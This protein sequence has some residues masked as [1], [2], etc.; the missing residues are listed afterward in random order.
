M[1]KQKGNRQLDNMLNVDVRRSAP[2]YLQLRQNIL[3]LIEKQVLKDGDKLPSETEIAIQ[4]N[5]SRGTVRTA[6]AELAREGIISRTP[7]R[8]SFLTLKRPTYSIKIGVFSPLFPTK[9]DSF[10]DFFQAELIGGIREAALHAG[11]TL[12]FLP[13][14]KKEDDLGYEIPFREDMDAILILAPRKSDIPILYEIEK[15][16]MPCISISAATGSN[17][18]YVASDNLKGAASVMEYLFSL[19][20]QRIALITNNLDCFDSQA[21]YDGYC[22]A[23][24]EHNLPFNKKI[25]KIIGGFE[26]GKWKDKAKEAAIKILK[27]EKR[28][29]AVFAAGHYLAIGANE[30]IE[31]MDLSIPED[32]SLVGFDD[33]AFASNM[34]PSLTTISQPVWE[35]GK[36]GVEKAID[37]VNGKIKPP[38]HIILETELIIRNSC[39]RVKKREKKENG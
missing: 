5:L 2:L 8:G 29:T 27:E 6:L 30:G 33:F 31:E 28:V 35:L 36:V 16:K 21:R 25:V 24:K 11:A 34:S 17:F 15:R 26:A 14:F 9:R 10:P 39:G 12:L 32:I 23:L 13:N 20:H 38:L 22:H 7:K 37:L 4:N 19:G 3:A 1:Y 18:N